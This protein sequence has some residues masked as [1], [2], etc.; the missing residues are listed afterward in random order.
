MLQETDIL[1]EEK[2]TLQEKHE[3]P[4][5]SADNAASYEKEQ[6]RIFGQ[7]TEQLNELQQCFNNKIAEDAH[8]NKLFDDMHRQLVSYQNGVIDKITETLVLDIIQ[9][10]DS[11]KR[12]Y[13]LYEKKD[14]TEDNYIGLLKIVKGISEDLEDILYR[15][16]IES[17]QVDGEE[18]DVKRQKIIRIVETDDRSRDNLIAERVA[19]GY[20]KEGKVIR[21]ERIKIYKCRLKDIEENKNTGEE[22]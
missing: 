9:L 7:I 12:Y 20:E 16:N 10:I 14:P 1:K 5:I 2:N 3:E 15:Q 21:P 13:R 17:Y 22:G 19:E 18:V 4:D 6:N 11:A 8:K